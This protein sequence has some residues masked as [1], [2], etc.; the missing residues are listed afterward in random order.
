M[1]RLRGRVLCNVFSVT[2]LISDTSNTETKSATYFYKYKTRNPK[3]L[4]CVQADASW[5]KDQKKVWVTSRLS[6]MYSGLKARVLMEATWHIHLNVI[7]QAL[8]LLWQTYLVITWNVLSEWSSQFLGSSED[9]KRDMK[10]A[11]S[12]LPLLCSQPPIFHRQLHP[13]PC[14]ASQAYCWT[15]Q[16]ACSGMSKSCLHSSY[17]LG[18]F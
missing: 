2:W 12:M 15:I 17:A 4:L 16:S 6:L 14:Q 3:I 13:T 18:Q 1:K 11:S 9:M 10:H 5:W 8:L 7:H